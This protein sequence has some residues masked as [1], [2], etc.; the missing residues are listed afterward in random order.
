MKGTVSDVITDTVDGVG[1]FW[2]T[3]VGQAWES[4]VDTVQEKVIEPIREK[5]AQA[6][7]VV[8]SAG[9]FINEKVT[10]LQ[11]E[12]Q[13]KITALDRQVDGWVESLPEPAK[14]ILRPVTLIGDV[15]SVTVDA[16]WIDADQ[17][18]KDLFDDVTSSLGIAS[19]VVSSVRAAIKEAQQLGSELIPFDIDCPGCQSEFYARR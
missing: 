10:G 15:A 17:P 1:N 11:D 5:G 12:L 14:T 4:A 13:E 8:K 16:F 9:A 18:L 7:E 2:D 19:D 6:V 3:T